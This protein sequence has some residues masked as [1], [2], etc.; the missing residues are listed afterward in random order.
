LQLA[1]WISCLWFHINLAPL[2]VT[3]VS[4]RDTQ[5]QSNNT[6]FQ[7]MVAE[8][9]AQKNAILF[10]PFHYEFGSRR[11]FLTTRFLHRTC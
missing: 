9:H 2:L 10:R 11:T 8:S 3:L 1:S 5:G 4:S 6:C 7:A